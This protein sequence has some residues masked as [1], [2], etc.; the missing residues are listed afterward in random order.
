MRNVSPGM[1]TVTRRRRML[2]VRECITSGGNRTSSTAGTT[3][4]QI[5]FIPKPPILPLY[6]VQ[7][8]HI[9]SGHSRVISIHAPIGA[10]GPRL[11]RRIHRT[12]GE[13]VVDMGDMLLG[14][15][16]LLFCL[17][18]LYLLF[19]VLTHVLVLKGCDC[20]SNVFCIQ[21][22]LSVQAALTMNL[23]H[24]R[25]TIPFLNSL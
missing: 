21:G 7:W 4:S 15:G 17:Y 1:K 13:A 23:S 18:I 19:N 8:Q 11:L 2:S 16:F 14:F 25:C 9:D 20:V 5:F 22:H 10:Q 12:E 6:H 24:G 3:L